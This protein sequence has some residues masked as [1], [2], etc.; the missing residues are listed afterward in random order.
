MSYS[1][2]VARA[3]AENPHFRAVLHTGAK[4]QLV[5]MNLPAGED[6]GEETHPH[7][8]QILYFQSGTGTAVLDGVETPVGPGDVV[9]VAPGVRHNFRNT[10]TEP[11]RLFTVYV[12]PNHIDGRIHPTKADAIADVEDEEFGEAVR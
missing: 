8:E 1:A 9:F 11:L 7:I 6:V 4:S 5:V 12:P 2:N 3:T 10:G